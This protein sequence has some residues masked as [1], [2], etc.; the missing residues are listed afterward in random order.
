M[1]PKAMHSGSETGTSSTQVTDPVC[2]MKVD[3]QRAAGRWNYHGQTYYFCGRRCLEKFQANPKEFLAAAEPPAR[4][5]ELLS[6]S[7][8]YVC[9]MDPEVHEPKPGACPKCGMALEPE[10]V[11]APIARTE[12]VCPMHPQIVRQEPGS[13]PICGM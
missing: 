7:T 8:P 12:Y 4:A 6:E 11:A 1:N 2:G 9:P 13:C 3:P 5:S 10:I